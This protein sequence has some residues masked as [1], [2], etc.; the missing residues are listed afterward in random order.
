MPDHRTGSSPCRCS[1]SRSR[2]T[3]LGAVLWLAALNVCYRDVRLRLP[4]LTQ[5]WLFATPIAYSSTPRSATVAAARTA[6]NPMAASSTA[7]A[8]RCSVRATPPGATL[9]GLAAPCVSLLL[10]GRHST[11]SA[12]WN[13]PSPTSSEPGMTSRSG[14]TALGKRYA[15][16]RA[17][18][19]PHAARGDRRS[20]AR[21]R[22]RRRA[23]RSA[24]RRELLGAA[25]RLVRDRAPARWSA[26]S[27]ATAPARAPCSRFSRASPRRPTGRAEIRGR[28]G[29]LLEVGT[30]F[31]PE[32]TGRENVYLNGAI[33]GMRKAGD[34]RASSTRSSRSPRSSSSSIRRSSATRAACTCGSRSPWRRT[35]SPRSASSTRC[36]PSATRRSRRSVS[37]RWETS[38]AADAPCCS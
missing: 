18:A 11:T 25:R 30:G 32:L 26:S 33:L 28:V 24:R 23:E 22:F 7:F 9:A 35:S 19:L 17:A 13:A 29:S 10:V 2:R 16:G 8:G 31:H 37:A 36:S 1:C 14:S 27:A 12:G 5:V 20:G 6:L 3:A 4:F 38:R 34:R 21:S 15:L